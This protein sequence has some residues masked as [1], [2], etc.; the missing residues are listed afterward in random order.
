ML[1]ILQPD[2]LQETRV[3]KTLAGSVFPG[4]RHTQLGRPCV[5][6]LALPMFTG[7][8][9][10]KHSRSSANGEGTHPAGEGHRGEGQAAANGEATEEGG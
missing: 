7:E 10:T 9:K 5:E 3:L 4:Q 8:G 6:H 2:G 1:S